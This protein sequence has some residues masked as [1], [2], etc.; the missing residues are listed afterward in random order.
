MHSPP[1]RIHMRDETRAELME[2]VRAYVNDKGRE[3]TELRIHKAHMG[4]P[5]GW[6]VTDENLWMFRQYRNNVSGSAAH[7]VDEALS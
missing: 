6:L 5:D 2:I 1:E 3:L 7:M 4:S